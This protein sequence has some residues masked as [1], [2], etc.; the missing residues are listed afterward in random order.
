MALRDQPYLPLYVQDFLT[1]EKLAE[2]SASAN[3]VYIRI[4]CLMHKSE[5]YG[6]ISLKEKDICRGKNGGK[7]SGKY[8][9]KLE[10]FAGKLAR[11]LPY[12]FDEIEAGLEELLDEGVLT[13]DGNTLCQKRMIRDA[14]ISEKRAVSGRRGATSTNERY[15]NPNQKGEDFADKFAEAK[16][17]ANTENEYENKNDIDIDKK[18]KGIAK[19]KG[20]K[21]TEVLTGEIVEDVEFDSFKEWINTNAPRV[22]KMDEPFTRDQYYEITRIYKLEDV[23]HTLEAMHN[24]KKLATRSAYLT[25]RNWLRRDNVPEIGAQETAAPAGKVGSALGAIAGALRK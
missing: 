3:G 4:M 16:D 5:E 13:I 6:K 1:D 23:K 25:C 14:E 24:Y 8:D 10:I 15:N 21:K 7:V 2:C 17:P 18:G 22:A 20:S 11:H 9:G 19:G 12:N